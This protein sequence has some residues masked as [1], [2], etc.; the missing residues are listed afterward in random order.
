MSV[1][2]GLVRMLLQTGSNSSEDI[3]DPT[4]W[5]WLDEEPVFR[6]Y[7]GTNAQYECVVDEVDYLHF[8]QWLWIPKFSN[9][10]K[11]V[12]FRRAVN[13]YD[14]HGQRL[15]A[16]SIYLHIEICYRTHG[17]PPSRLRCIADHL[18]GDSSDNRRIN[19]R[20]ATRREN[21]RNRF[22][23]AFYQRRLTI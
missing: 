3:F 10:G 14:N 5:T 15:G 18:N 8:T 16:D 4:T 20:W 6:M 19:L 12:Y 21:N 1:S 2:R 22:G 13:R 17:P 7:A 11:K 9:R 23:S